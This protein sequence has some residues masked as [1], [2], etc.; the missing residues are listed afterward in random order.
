M[1]AN[2]VLTWGIAFLQWITMPLLVVAAQNY[3]KG[4]VGRNIIVLNVVI[5]ISVAAI[6]ILVP[7][8]VF[9]I[10]PLGVLLDDYRY[11]AALGGLLSIP[12]TRFVRH[13]WTRW[14]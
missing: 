10:L 8:S 12:V 14:S 1:D 9:G 13:R 3:I 7:L 5:A 4:I 6:V 2:R 11:A